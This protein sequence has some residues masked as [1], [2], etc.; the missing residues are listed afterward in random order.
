MLFC[1]ITSQVPGDEN[2]N[3]LR[4]MGG[5][6]FPYLIYLNADGERLGVH[7]GPRSVAAFKQSGAA[8]AASAT[9]GQT[10]PP[11]AGVPLLK[12]LPLIL[13]PLVVVAVVGVAVFRS[14]RQGS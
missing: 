14:M 8:F 4:Q 9:P 12:I 1:H 2:Q 5:R 6:G 11:S 7:N 3:L 10:A 13:L